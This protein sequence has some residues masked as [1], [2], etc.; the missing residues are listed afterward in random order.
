VDSGQAL[1]E[2]VA[3]TSM[4]FDAFDERWSMIADQVL[5]G[6]STNPLQCLVVG[7]P[8]YQFEDHI[9][10]RVWCG[11]DQAN[12]VLG[13]RTVNGGRLAPFVKPLSYKLFPLEGHI[14]ILHDYTIQSNSLY[15]VANNAPPTGAAGVNNK[16]APTTFFT[17]SAAAPIAAN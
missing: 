10:S 15:G 17:T 9:P 16:P 7:C 4:F 12:E 5:K 6:T 13:G 2:T 14:M 1:F 8:F 11:L 3:R